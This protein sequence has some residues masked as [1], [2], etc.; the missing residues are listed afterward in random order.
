MD[1]EIKKIDGKERDRAVGLLLHLF[2]KRTGKRQKV[3]AEEAGISAAYLSMLEDGRRRIPIDMIHRLTDTLS[4]RA[5]KK[6]MLMKAAGYLGSA[7]ETYWT[8]Q[9]ILHGT[10]TFIAPFKRGHH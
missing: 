3:L 7:F 6:E 1:R 9:D 4:L 8:I 2:R 10:L 5:R